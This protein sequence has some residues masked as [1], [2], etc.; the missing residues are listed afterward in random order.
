MDTISNRRQQVRTLLA[1]SL[2]PLS[3]FATDIYIPSLPSMAANIGVSASAV[4]LSLV[5]FMA[6]SGIAQLFVG[7]LLDSFGRYKLGLS[8]L[9]I[10]SV[11]SF[12]IAITRDIHLIYAMRIVEGITV[13]LIVVGKRAYFMDTFSGDRLKNYTSLFSII[14]AASPILAP[15]LG[16]YLESI[17]GWHSNFY[18]LGIATMFLLI[19]ELFFGAESLKIR[20]HFNLKNIV[21][22]YTSTIKTPD[23]TIGLLMISLSY[24]IL[25]IYGMSAPF[26]VEHVFH[27]PAVVTGY[28]SLISG[29]CLMGGGIISKTLINRPLNKKLT[30]G[31][32]FQLSVAGLM[33]ITAAS[34]SNIITLI[35]FT[36]IVHITSGFLFNNVFA[37]CLGRFSGNAG[38]ASGITGGGLFIITSVISYGTVNVLGIHDQGKLG[39]AY[40]IFALL[41]LTAFYFFRK[42]RKDIVRPVLT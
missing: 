5:L 26:I 17:F 25:V 9:F 18:F 24:A 42:S 14:W 20:N 28:C 37:Y 31:I 35:A 4:Q 1:F 29:V 6:S 19:L 40:V 41:W 22:I 7:S 21:G 12:V 27:Y 13:A 33:A 2:I 38:V 30:A 11:A 36:A 8:S 3:G 15:F 16:G 23:F 10:F 39:I 32:V 34:Y